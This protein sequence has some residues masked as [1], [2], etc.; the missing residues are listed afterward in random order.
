[1]DREERRE[2]KARLVAVMLEG[3]KWHQAADSAVIRTSR[4]AAYRLLRLARS[5]G[6]AALEERRHGHPYKLT[7][8]VREWLVERCRG[9][10]GVSGPALQAG[11]EQQFG[12][13]V[14]TSQINRVRAELG[15]SSRSR[16]VGGKIRHLSRLSPSGGRVLVHSCSWP[17]P[18]RRG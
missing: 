8:P 4:T 9:M 6:D 12:I 13:I 3:R 11:I 10:P 14:S 17:Q 5:E 1:M 15:V 2:R 18:T 16:C 7:T